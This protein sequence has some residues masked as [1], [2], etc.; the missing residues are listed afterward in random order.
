M[1]SF[2]PNRNYEEIHFVDLRRPSVKD[3]IDESG[4]EDPEGRR[5]HWQWMVSGHIRNQW[6]PSTEDHKL[7]WVQPYMKGPLGLPVK[8][9]AYHVKR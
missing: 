8:P 3:G 2:M 6:Y 9:R 1:S 5:Y 4:E 7:I